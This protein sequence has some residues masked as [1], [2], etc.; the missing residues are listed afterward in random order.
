MYSSARMAISWSMTIWQGSLARFPQVIINCRNIAIQNQGTQEQGNITEVSHPRVFRYADGCERFHIENKLTTLLRH[1][2]SGLGLLNKAVS[3]FPFGP[4]FHVTD[5]AHLLLHN[6]S[7]ALIEVLVYRCSLFM[8]KCDNATLVRVTLTELLKNT[9]LALKKKK[10][11]NTRLSSFRAVAIFR[12]VATKRN[13]IKRQKTF[14]IYKP[15]LMST[16]SK[17]Y[18]I[19][20]SN[21]NC[22]QRLA[23]SHSGRS[24]ACS[25]VPFQQQLKCAPVPVCIKG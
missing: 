4:R 14:L 2:S 22:N 10:K 15:G 17:S 11:V 23:L 12:K 1:S 25:T 5:P 24:H 16:S 21:C 7:F 20:V 8:W 6:I 9:I 3:I 18:V 13:G 19:P